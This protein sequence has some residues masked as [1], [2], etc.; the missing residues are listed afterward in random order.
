MFVIY[1]RLLSSPRSSRPH[2]VRSH[3]RLPSLPK[4]P[5]TFLLFHVSLHLP[6]LSPL[7]LSLSLSPILAIRVCLMQDLR[8]LQNKTKKKKHFLGLGLLLRGEQALERKKKKKKK[9]EERCLRRR[10]TFF[11]FPWLKFSRAFVLIILLGLRSFGSLRE[12]ASPFVSL[13][14]VWPDLCFFLGSCKT[15]SISLSTSTCVACFM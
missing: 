13:A 4:L 7:S 14:K 15:R 1:I 6:P 3:C 10:E 12:T 9:K 2:I 5:A 11:C 8:S